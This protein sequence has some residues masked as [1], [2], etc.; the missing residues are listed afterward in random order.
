[1][2]I[3]LAKDVFELTFADAQARIIG[4]SRLNRSAF[5]KT[6]DNRAPLRVAMEACGSAGTYDAARGEHDDQQWSESS[7]QK[8]QVRGIDRKS[9]AS[10]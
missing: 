7:G 9:L 8:H 3:H 4:R 1:V 10:H 5:A 2:A 6:L